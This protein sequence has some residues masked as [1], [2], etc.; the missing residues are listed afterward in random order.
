[1]AYTL[2]TKPATVHFSAGF[3]ATSALVLGV[4]PAVGDI[5]IVVWGTQWKRSTSSVNL[6]TDLQYIMYCVLLL[7]PLQRSH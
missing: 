1:M 5:D 4:W 3:E 2:L 6:E 7:L